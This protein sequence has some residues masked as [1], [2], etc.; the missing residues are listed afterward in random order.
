MHIQT[1]EP[2]LTIYYLRMMK[3]A[4]LHA[5]NV[6]LRQGFI[7]KPADHVIG[8]TL[9]GYLISINISATIINPNVIDIAAYSS[10]MNRGDY[11]GSYFI[12]YY[13]IG[14]PAYYIY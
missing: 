6:S 3:I 13:Y 11:T 9:S 1:T 10:D 2:E 4:A 7:C 8:I 14:G 5:A 12:C